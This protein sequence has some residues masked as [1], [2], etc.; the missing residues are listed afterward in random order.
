[1]QNSNQKT[2]SI[3]A[4]KSQ[5]AEQQTGYD[6]VLTIDDR[7][8]GLIKSVPG[9]TIDDVIVTMDR[10]INNTYWREE[11]Q[12]ASYMTYAV[13][14]IWEEMTRL[15]LKRDYLVDDFTTPTSE[16]MNRAVRIIES[17]IKEREQVALYSYEG[18]ILD[19]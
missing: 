5:S 10:I 9:I 4:H 12:Q 1:M 7:P 2:H 3:N 17:N 6:W 13:N 18:S 11:V 19:K 16:L 15:L 8:F 14:L